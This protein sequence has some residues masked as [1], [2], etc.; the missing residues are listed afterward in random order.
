MTRDVERAGL[1]VTANRAGVNVHVL[2]RG[3]RVTIMYTAEQ[4]RLLADTLDATAELADKLATMPPQ[5]GTA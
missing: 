5:E 2:L 3:R 1:Q 4:A